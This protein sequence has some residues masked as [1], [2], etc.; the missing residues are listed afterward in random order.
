MK[1]EF[2]YKC[3][4]GR[5]I[6]KET[7]AKGEVKEKIEEIKNYAERVEKGESCDEC[8]AEVEK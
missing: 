3:K 5:V 1:I 6:G 7:E 2:F 4:D 8:V